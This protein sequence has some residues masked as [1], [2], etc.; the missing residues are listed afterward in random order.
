[1]YGQ[2]GIPSTCEVPP[3]ITVSIEARFYNLREEG[4]SII[5]EALVDTGS[6]FS[7]LPAPTSGI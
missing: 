4:R 6:T 2:R 1:M 5:L 3:D 7:G